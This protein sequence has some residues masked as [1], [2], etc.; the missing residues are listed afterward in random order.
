[1]GELILMLHTK[2]QK[3]KSVTGIINISSLGSQI[4]LIKRKIRIFIKC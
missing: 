4:F 1:M 2:H 3:H